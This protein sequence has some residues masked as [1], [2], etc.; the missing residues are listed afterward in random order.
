MCMHKSEQILLSCILAYKSVSD[1]TFNS[2]SPMLE[3][4]DILHVKI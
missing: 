1:C 4:Y 2:S 3:V